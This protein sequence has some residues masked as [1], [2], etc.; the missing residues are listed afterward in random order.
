[1]VIA[2]AVRGLEMGGAKRVRSTR[3]G[4]SWIWRS[5]NCRNADLPRNRPVQIFRMKKTKAQTCGLGRAYVSAQQLEFGRD[6]S[7]LDFTAD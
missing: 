7:A 5:H 2:G 3:H 6:D 4:D 1:M